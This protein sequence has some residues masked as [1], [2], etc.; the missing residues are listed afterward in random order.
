MGELYGRGINLFFDVS[1]RTIAIVLSLTAFYLN[2][3]HTPFETTTQLWETGR[4]KN[5]YSHFTG[6]RGPWAS[7]SYFLL[8]G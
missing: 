4:I 5:Y 3:E 6:S 2:S 7:I 1:I 8:A